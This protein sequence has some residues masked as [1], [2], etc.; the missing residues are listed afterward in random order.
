MYPCK[1]N[2]TFLSFCPAKL[3]QIQFFVSV[4]V[5]RW[6]EQVADRIKKG[7]YLPGIREGTSQ[8]ELLAPS[9]LPTAKP[10]KEQPVI[11]ST[12]VVLNLD[13][14][15]RPIPC[16]CL[17]A[18]IRSLTSLLLL[19]AESALASNQSSVNYQFCATHTQ[20]SCRFHLQKQDRTVN[21]LKEVIFV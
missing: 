1:H 6:K 21:V 16:L 15:P 12:T 4:I 11:T 8:L 17:F 14:A 7:G 5:L 2:M 13:P 19:A 3:R 9:P 18:S 10:A 20:P